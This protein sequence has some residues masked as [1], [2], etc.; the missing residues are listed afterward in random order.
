MSRNDDLDLISVVVVD[1]HPIAREGLCALLMAEPDLQVVGE[2]GD[3]LEAIRLVEQLQPDVLVL[4]LK[5]PG[6]DGHEV[7]RRVSER[8]P[9]T[10]TIV[11]SMHRS[12]AYVLQALK[13]GASGYVLKGSGV[14]ELIQAIREVV[15]GR[16]YL[17]PPFTE[18]ALELY[19]QKARGARPE[20]E[21][22]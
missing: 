8:W 19:M 16:R 10:R 15:R 22:A 6:L 7:T 9:E 17:G 4:D 13:C 20:S 14:T 11:L 5:M 12:E 2:A 21:R 1:D 3:G 18:R